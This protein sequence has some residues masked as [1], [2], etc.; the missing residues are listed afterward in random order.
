MSNEC[1]L[2]RMPST[3]RAAETAFTRVIIPI[4]SP[5]VTFSHRRSRSILPGSP[6][7]RMTRNTTMNA[8]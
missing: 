4:I 2:V 5:V 1:P 8:G 3:R 7:T 6:T